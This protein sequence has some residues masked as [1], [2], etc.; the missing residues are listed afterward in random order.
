MKRKVIQIANSTQLISLPRKWSQK[1]GVMKGDEIDVEENGNQLLIRTDKDSHIEELD[2]DASKLTPFLADRLIARAYQKGYDVVR[3]RYDNTE[4]LKAMQNKLRE[5]LGF[6]IMEQTRNTIEI[7]V[8]SSR[9]DVDFDTSLRKAFLVLLDM[10]DLCEKDFKK[11][12][13]KALEGIVL[14]DED[15]NK[16]C[17]FCLRSI[18]KYQTHKLNATVMSYLIESLEDL[19]DEYKWLA[20]N[21]AGVSTKKDIFANL[22]EQLNGILKT[23]YDFFYKPDK[24]KVII[25]MDGIEKMQRHVRALL[26][27]NNVNEISALLNAINILNLFYKFIT[28]RLDTLKEVTSSQPK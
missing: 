23:T 19:G 18:N 6:E 15:I 27:T 4:Q 11:N 3:V 7:R 20:K 26:K 22:V 2:I 21:L 16:Y 12:D 1:Y 17:Y 9:L 14:R 24:D 25:A 28:M 13:K 8:L 5:L 10:A